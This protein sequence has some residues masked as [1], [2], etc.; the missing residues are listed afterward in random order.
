MKLIVGIGNPEVKYN[1]SRHNIGFIVL[2][3]IAQDLGCSFS[4]EKKID[5]EIANC[6]LGEEKYILLKPQTYV[7]NSGQSVKKAK[8]FYKL[9]NEDILVVHDDLDIYFGKVKYDF[10]RSSAGHNGIESVIHYLKTKKFHRIRVGIRNE[11]LDEIKSKD[12]ER[13]KK[14]ALVGKFVLSE[15]D[16]EE[17][18][19]F[20]DIYQRL[21][22]LI[23]SSL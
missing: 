2:D 9:K 1:S 21:F 5:G 11:K 7:N 16:K 19:E 13:D 8:S 14:T 18:K 6:N 17:K 4:F 22:D 10:D 3:R 12:I 23:K 15:F 20:D